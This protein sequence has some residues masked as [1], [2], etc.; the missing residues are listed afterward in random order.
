[1][2]RAVLYSSILHV[3]VLG[4]AYFHL[5]DLIFPAQ[6]LEDTPIAI[7]LV[8]IAPE[9]RA[10][11]P[12]QTPPKPKAKPE[13]QNVEAPQPPPKQPPKPVPPP[14]APPP[15]AAPPP[16]PAPQPQVAQAQPEP[17]K[18]QPKPEQP[19][20]P[21][22]PPAPA[23]TPKPPPPEPPKPTPP[24]PPPPP[25]KPAPPPDPNKRKQD[26]QAFDA[27]L[28]NLSKRAETQK[29]EAP[30]S[31]VQP[32]QQAKASSQPIAPLGPQL[33]T[34][35]IDLVK[36][37]IEHCWSPSAAAKEAHDLIVDITA[38]VSPDGHVLT[39]RIT[40]TARMGDPFYRSAA[41]SALRAVLNP[42][43]SPLKLPP[44]KYEQWKIINMTF[45]PKDLL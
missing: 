2:R 14:P 32:Q 12:N 24:P 15:S 22:P 38:E 35:E 27:L 17:P 3:S 41:E 5:W 16:T 6:P 29:S 23:P 28:K 10:T 25:P 13:D 31:R 9:T 44:E 8:N 20:P 19:P 45:N 34:S 39:A 30:P 7:E 18:A 36:Q 4:L 40:S 21:P 37:Q 11:R 43:C 1:M 42:Q 33:T 26:E